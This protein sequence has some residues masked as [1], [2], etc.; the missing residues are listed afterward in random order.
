M[1]AK[2]SS[3]ISPH[4]KTHGLDGEPHLSTETTILLR[5][6]NNENQ[7]GKAV[8]DEAQVKLLKEKGVEAWNEWRKAN[9]KT[10]PNLSKADFSS[11]TVGKAGIRRRFVGDWRQ[12]SRRLTGIRPSLMPRWKD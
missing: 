9:L 5:S 12:I 4:F 6:G 3:T 8:A 7:G 10:E 2:Y 1:L 11:A